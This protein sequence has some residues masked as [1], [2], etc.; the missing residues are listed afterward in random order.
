MENHNQPILDVLLGMPNDVLNMIRSR[1]MLKPLIQR[2]IVDD[3]VS[4][5]SINQQQINQAMSN[6]A[7]QQGIS[8]QNELYQHC[9]SNGISEEELINQVILPIKIAVYSQQEF[10]PKAESHFLQRKEDLDQVSYSLIRVTD[11]G[12][13]HELYLQ[14][15]A[16]EVA[17]EKLAELHSQGPEKQSKGNIPLNA[18]SR[19]HPVLR[20]KLRTVSEGILMEPFEIEQWWVIA[21]LNERRSCEFDDAMRQRMSTEL[22]NQWVDQSVDNIMG[23]ISQNLASEV[24]AA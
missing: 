6:F 14:I 9:A 10:G 1:C 22:F 21:R 17:F 19:A 20:N 13:A 18:L 24:N 7:Q 11:K 16:G 23:R 3:A 5:I 12:L 2:L 4:K 8:N 15:E